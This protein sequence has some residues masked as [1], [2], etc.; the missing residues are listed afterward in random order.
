[1]SHSWLRVELNHEC[2]SSKAV[3]TRESSCHVRQFSRNIFRQFDHEV[4]YDHIKTIS[5]SALKRMSSVPTSIITQK[6]RML[7]MSVSISI[8]WRSPGLVLHRS[9]GSSIYG[10]DASALNPSTFIRHPPN[11]A[12]ISII[13]AYRCGFGSNTNSHVFER[14]QML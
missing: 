3:T 2:T 12:R 13:A 8:T 6:I 14:H 10:L 9:R 1:M 5:G 7:T 4:T 11:L